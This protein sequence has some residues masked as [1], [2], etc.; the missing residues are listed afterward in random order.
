MMLLLVWFISF[1]GFSV[2]SLGM[3]RH[4]KSLQLSPLTNK[5]EKYYLWVGLAILKGS[6]ILVFISFSNAEAILIWFG[7]LSIAVLKVV[8][9][10]SFKLHHKLPKH[11]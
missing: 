9:Y 3:A 8:G 10:L 2:L 4:R 11:N 6:L 1:L 5:Q 7:L